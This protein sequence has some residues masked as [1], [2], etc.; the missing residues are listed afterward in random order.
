MTPSSSDFDEIPLPHG[1]VEEFHES[2]HP[3]YVDTL[4]N[5]PRSIWIHPYEDEQYLQQHPEDGDKLQDW[6]AAHRSRSPSPST[7]GKSPRPLYAGDVKVPDGSIQELY[8]Y[9][10]PGGTPR[11][12]PALGMSSGLPMGDRGLLGERGISGRSERGLLGGRGL[13]GA[14][15][16]RAEMAEEGRGA[17]HDPRFGM[18]GASGMMMGP[19]QR[20]FGIVDRRMER[21]MRHQEKLEHR[22]Q[23]RQEKFER[24]MERR[25]GGR[26][27]PPS[28]AR[29][30]YYPGQYSMGYGQQ[31]GGPSQFYAPPPMAA[32]PHK[33]EHHGGQVLPFLGGV[34][35]GVAGDEL[36]HHFKDKKEDKD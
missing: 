20:G 24:R 18:G 34:A 26:Y 8:D 2:G 22:M 17:Y 32:T 31:Y 5:P 23:R 21:D 19:S 4:A 36:F 12:A 14:L 30:A 10:T 25:F 13:I 15:V 29:P 28:Y 16:G 9:G 35:V 27:T 11:G 1:W 7:A 3:Y 6:V 33:E